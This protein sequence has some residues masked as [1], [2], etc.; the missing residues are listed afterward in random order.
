MP[1]YL[2]DWCEPFLQEGDISKSWSFIGVL[3]AKQIFFK[4][5]TKLREGRQIVEEFYNLEKEY[6]RLFST[7]QMD[8]NAFL[9]RKKEV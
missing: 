1:F 4:K 6:Y 3:E 2:V 9:P 5:K 7:K 8:K